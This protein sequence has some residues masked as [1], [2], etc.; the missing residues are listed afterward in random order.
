M[1][2]TI[3]VLPNK[4]AFIHPVLGAQ[5]ACMQD[6]HEHARGATGPMIRYVGAKLS[7]ARTRITERRDRK[8]AF[9]VPEDHRENKQVTVFEFTEDPV[10]LPMTNYYIDRLRDGSLVPA[11]DATMEI[12]GGPTRVRFASL[13]DAE[14]AARTKWDAGRGKEGAFDA[15]IKSATALDETERAACH[16]DQGHQ[17]QEVLAPENKEG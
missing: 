12:A 7:H 10:T 5:G 13:K 3:S 16:E 4:F 9:G 15:L 6:P 8:G 17:G 14:A 1:R 11:D 2:K